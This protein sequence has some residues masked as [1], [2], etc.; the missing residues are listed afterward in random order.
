M[1]A[2]LSPPP[3]PLDADEWRWIRP[4]VQVDVGAAQSRVTDMERALFKNYAAR[5]DAHAKPFLPILAA[6]LPSCALM[7]S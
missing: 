1:I 3:S 4:E 7:R 5:T 2:R 6:L